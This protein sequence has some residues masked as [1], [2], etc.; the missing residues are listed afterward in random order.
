L[1]GAPKEQ[2]VLSLWRGNWANVMRIIPA[3]AIRFPAYDTY[4]RL[5]LPRG[6]WGYSVLFLVF[7]VGLTPLG[8]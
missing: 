1:I 6:E 3:T 7:F 2:G 8:S 4:K 5:S